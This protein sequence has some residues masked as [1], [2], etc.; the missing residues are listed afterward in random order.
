MALYFISAASGTGRTTL[1]YELRNH[2]KLLNKFSLV[3]PDM[4]EEAIK[5]INTAKG[6]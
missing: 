3:T 5:W 1:M 4:F 2:D 6:K